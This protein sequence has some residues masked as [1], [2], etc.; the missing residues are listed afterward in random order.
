[1]KKLLISLCAASLLAASVAGYAGSVTF[2]NKYSEPVTFVANQGIG[3]NP[4]AGGTLGP[5][6]TV[7][8]DTIGPFDT[9]TMFMAFRP[10]Q[11][12][13]SVRNCGVPPGPMDVATVVAD[14]F[15]A[16]HSFSC[17]AY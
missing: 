7:T 17:H 6:E 9:N 5:G 11:S 4:V 16:P 13:E 8:V 10:A 1:M 15:V 14:P 2:V 3:Y 12:I